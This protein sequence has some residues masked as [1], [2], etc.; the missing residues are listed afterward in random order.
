MPVCPLHWGAGQQQ[1]HKLVHHRPYHWDAAGQA[2][3]ADKGSV[4]VFVC[5]RCYNM[6]CATEWPPHLQQ[7]VEVVGVYG[8]S[9][10]RLGRRMV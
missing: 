10:S 1:K 2:D 6:L 7:C 8:P 4:H 9:V 5:Y 3:I